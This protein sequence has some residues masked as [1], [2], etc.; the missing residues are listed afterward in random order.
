MQGVGSEGL[1]MALNGYMQSLKLLIE[2]LIS[3]RKDCPVSLA[4]SKV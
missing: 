4:L 2:R 1:E 3:A